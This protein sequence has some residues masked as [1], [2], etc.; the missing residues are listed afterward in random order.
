ME[1]IDQLDR[2]IL[3]ILSDNAR[4]PFKE[5][6]AL[7]KVSRASVHQRVQ[8]LID[9]HIILGSSFD[10]NPVYLGY[11]LLTYVGVHLEHSKCYPHVVEDL[12]AIPEVVECHCV[13]GSY[14]ILL[15]L[16]AHDN[17]HLM[18]LLNAQVQTIA[19]VVSTE[20]LVCLDE[21]IR[22]ELPIQIADE[23]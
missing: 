6:A 7:C 17:A 14:D 18:S 12:K 5:V 21:S 4:V 20:T 19:G 1:K 2:K 9:N 22:R 8:R 13:T 15:K 3:R 16:Y 23:K 10:V 11:P